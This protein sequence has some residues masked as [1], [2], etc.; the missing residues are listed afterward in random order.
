MPALVLAA[1]SSHVNALIV[2]VAIGFGIGI[3]GHL[4]RSRMLIVLGI[5]IIGVTSAYVAF[6]LQ[7]GG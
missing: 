2:V 7:P 3:T 4:I 1:Q 5:V 6:V